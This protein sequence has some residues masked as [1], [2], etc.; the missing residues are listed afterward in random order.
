[1]K[2]NNLIIILVLSA[3]TFTSCMKDL[4]IVPQNPNIITAA[5]LSNDPVI[6][7]Q[8]LAKIYASFLISGQGGSDSDIGV[9]DNEDF[10][11]TMRAVWNLQQLPTDETICA[12]GD[13][14]ISEMNTQLWSNSNPFLTALFQRLGLTVTF[15]NDFIRFTKEIDTPLAKRYRAEARFL[16]AL[17]YYYHLDLFGNPPFTTESDPVGAFFP[18]QLDQNF[19]TGRKKLFEYIEAELK[20]IVSD[21]GEPALSYPNADKAAAWMLLARLY[22]NA[23]VYTGTPRWADVVTY[24]NLVENSAKY[25]LAPNYR[26]NFSA[27]NGYQEGNL[28][29]IFAW[30]QDGHR[31]NGWVGTTFIIQSCSDR[32]Y[33]RSQDFHGLTFNPNWDGNRATR[34]FLNVMIDTLATYGGAPVPYNTDS[35]FKTS[36]DKRV[37]LKRK[38]SPDIPSPTSPGSFG[39]GVYKFTANKADGTFPATFNTSFANTDYP[40]FRYADALLMRAEANF[41]LG[42]PNAAN[43]F[44]AVRARAFGNNSQNVTFAQM[45]PGMIL[46]ERAREFYYEGHR[47]TDLVRFGQFTNGTYH[48]AWKGGAANGVA[49]SPHLNVFPIPAEEIAANPELVQNPVY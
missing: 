49:T 42:N 36:N 7:K 45:T 29:M 35:L 32:I 11:T 19:A 14:G 24:V 28:E 12:W 37:F 17:A 8:A 48:W 31:T 34:Q 6:L 22:L 40:I 39:I 41:R 5:D 18:R 33:I 15:A 38:L 1:M 26:K 30:S 46:T 27:D 3:F 23:E 21:L 10:Y 2:K 9:T 44:N 43:D 20:D 4:D 13:S 47:R 25:S 16:R